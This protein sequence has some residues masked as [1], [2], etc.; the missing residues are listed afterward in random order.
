MY[1]QCPFR[2]AFFAAV[3][4]P[5]QETPLHMRSGLSFPHV[6]HK[7]EDTPPPHPP[8]HRRDTRQLALLLLHNFSATRHHQHRL[9]GWQTSDCSLAARLHPPHPSPPCHDSFS[10]LLTAHTF[11]LLVRRCLK[12]PLP[13]ERSVAVCVHVPERRGDGNMNEC[14]T[15]PEQNRQM[16][17]PFFS[18]CGWIL[19]SQLSPW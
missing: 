8:K 15:W 10:I 19:S 6:H 11:P 16:S 7:N 17:H 18:K 2:R 12:W 4:I 5:S 14:H 13:L 9:V 1:V 3:F